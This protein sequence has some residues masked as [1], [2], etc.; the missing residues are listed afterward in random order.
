[1]IH[2][3]HIESTALLPVTESMRQT[4]QERQWHGEGDV[5]THTQMV[6]DALVSL[7]EYHKLSEQEQ[8]VVYLAAMLHDVGKIVTTSIVNGELHAPR[9]APIGSRMARKMLWTEYDMSGTTEAMQIREAVCMLI[10]YHSFPVHAIDMPD[11]R[12]RLHRIAANC[13][14]A[15]LFSVK[16]LCMLSKADMIGRTA[17]DLQESLERIAYCEELAREESC[18]DTTYVFPSAYTQ[19]AYLSGRDVWKQQELFDDTWGEVILMSG[20][21]GTGK[22]TWIAQHAANIPMVSLDAIR[23][24]KRISPKADQGYVANL[25]RE[26][27]K[28]FLRNHQSF[29][30]N[31]T[32]ITAPM[33]D[34]LVALFE[35]YHARVHIV[36][37]E[38][39]WHNLL[40]RNESR[41]SVVP[42]SAIE[43]ML[44]KTTLPEA[45]EAQT[46]EWHCI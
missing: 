39:T 33:R 29:V 10:R 30:W 14:L 43:K 5:W 11:A 19:R 18:Y 44:E 16:L 21:P 15:P 8:H 4:F 40:S 6:C 38:T 9:H 37:L 25:A 13:Q 23:Q 28:E 35:A 42:Q 3:Q 24:E 22:D 12:L 46:V 34:S 45:C 2:W 1:M 31:A 26:Q 41:P 27:A 36:Y 17:S 7:P 20:L 32:N